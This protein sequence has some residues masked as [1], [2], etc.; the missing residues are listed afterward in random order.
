MARLKA[1]AAHHAIT[2]FDLSDTFDRDDPATLEIAAW[3]DHPNATGHERLFEALARAHRRGP[4]ASSP[5][6]LPRRSS[7]PRTDRTPAAVGPSRRRRV[8][9][10][11]AVRA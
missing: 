10:V 6:L 7:D 5:L 11:T 2:T 3:D 8:D 4:D 9:E 1:L